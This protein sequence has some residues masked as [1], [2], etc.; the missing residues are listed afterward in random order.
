MN[1]DDA[2]EA[3]FELKVIEEQMRQLQRQIGQIEAHI[4]EFGNALKSIEELKSNGGGEAFVPVSSAI[5]AGA[6][7]LDA[8]KFVVNVGAGI[9]VEKSADETKAVIEKQIGDLGQYREQ[10]IKGLQLLGSRAEE[11][12]KLVAEEKNV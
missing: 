3:Y 8:G 10:M 11:I 6:K 7:I 12:E 2:R 1:E 4:S 5:F 9:A